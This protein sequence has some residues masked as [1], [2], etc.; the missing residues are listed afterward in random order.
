MKRV[1]GFILLLL[2]APMVA[3]AHVNLMPLVRAINAVNQF[4]LTQELP[5]LQSIN[6]LLKSQIGQQITGNYGIGDY[7]WDPKLHAWGDK[8]ASWDEVLKIYQAGGNPGDLGSVAKTL[9]KQFPIQNL[10]AIKN[11]NPRDAHRDYYNTQAKTAL[12]ARAASQVI[13]D[14]IQKEIELEQKLQEKID[15]TSNIKEAMDLQNRLQVENN[16]IQLEL[17]RLAAVTTQQQAITTQAD[18]NATVANASFFKASP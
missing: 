14:R 8:T 4:Q 5:Q 12:A 9:A 15:H 7:Q 13:F 10:N 1:A 3:A 18:V 2:Y 17:L 6:D 16:L 11:F